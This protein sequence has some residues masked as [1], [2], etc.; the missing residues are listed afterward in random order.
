MKYCSN[1]GQALEDTV[2]FCH[3][4]GA[5]QGETAPAQNAVQP[6]VQNYVQPPVQNY[7]Q[8][9]MYTPEQPKTSGVKGKVLGGIGFGLSLF[10]FIMSLICFVISISAIDAGWEADEL[11]GVSIGYT[12]VFIACSIIGMIFSGKAREDG[13]FSAL[14]TMAKVFGI[15]G[16]ILFG[17][18]FFFALVAV[19]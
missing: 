14:S 19:A 9:P 15:I 10:G 1:C 4:C 8:Q 2:V 13:N 12:L 16:T 17:L 18:A 7:V 5:R 11:A 6:P 3:N